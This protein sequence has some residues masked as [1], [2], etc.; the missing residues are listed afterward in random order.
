M[1]SD[2]FPLQPARTYCALLSSVPA[3]KLLTVGQ[4]RRSCEGESIKATNTESVELGMSS[5]TR[6][7]GYA[8]DG[9]VNGVPTSFLVDT[10]AAVTLLRV[11]CPSPL[12]LC[13]LV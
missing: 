7:Q 4:S 5:V 12:G 8:V 13:T 6:P 2:L 3:G 1:I 10:G 9:T 11:K